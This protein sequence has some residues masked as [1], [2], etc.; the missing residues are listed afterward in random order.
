MSYRSTKNS[1]HYFI[2]FLLC[3]LLTSYITTAQTHYIL[4]R[5]LNGADQSP[6]PFVHL[7]FN[8]GN[9]G[10]TTNIDGN[11]SIPDTVSQVQFSY[12]GFRPM[13]LE[14]KKQSVTS[15]V[16]YLVPDDNLLNTIEVYPRK[17][18]A[19]RIMQMVLNHSDSN[20]PDQLNSYQYT[21]YHK[22]WLS[23]DVPSE[24]KFNGKKMI[25]AR[26]IEKLQEKF[27]A[28]HMLL[29]ETLSKKKFLKPNHE[30]EEIISSKV[31]GLKKE[32]FFLLSNQLQS[33]SIYKQ[34]F[35]LLG[36]NYLSPIN[37]SALRNYA[38]VLEDTL[39]IENQDT[40]FRIR[41]HPAK[42][43]NFDG[44]KGFLHINT[45]GYAVESVIIEPASDYKKE[46]FASVWQH[47]IRI[48]DSHWFPAE[49]NAAVNF[50]M[51]TTLPVDSLSK[52][53]QPLKVSITANSRSYL[54][55]TDINPTLDPKSFPK[56]GVTRLPEKKDS[57]MDSSFRH[58]PL[59]PKDS[60]TYQ[61]L[62]SLGKKARIYRKVRFL[63]ALSLGTIPVG[64]VSINF[65]YLF[66]YN[67]NEGY[68]L[69]LGL[70]TNRKFSK[71]FTL[72]NYFTYGMRDR[73]F[74]HGEWLRIYP[75]GY[76]DFKIQL[77]YRDVKRDFGEEELLTDFNI[78]E[79]E[80]FRSLLI[81][82]MYRT[83]N[84]SAS[85][86]IRPIEPLNV[87]FYVDRSKNQRNS[88]G[89]FTEYKWDPFYLTKIGLEFRYSPGIAFMNNS[90]DLI[91]S[92]PPKSDFF[93][94]VIQGLKLFNSEY[95]FTKLDSK[96]KFQL[97]L[98]ALGT[99]TVMIRG[100]KIF[101]TAPI[102]DWFHG[103]GSNS[104]RFT[105]L[106]HYAF[107]TMGLNEFS[108][109]QYASLH[110]RH[111]FGT[112]F[113]PSWYFIRPELVLVQNIGV[114][115][116]KQEYSAL[117]GATDF[118][119]GFFESGIELNKILNSNITG[120]GFGTY[121]RYGPYKLSNKA[122]NFAYKLTINFKF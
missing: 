1:R 55:Q 107:A 88:Y 14:I 117:S 65:M 98:S 99:T 72:G 50:N 16:I 29:I 52:K 26:E 35:T 84:L 53:K 63:H 92:S 43:R 13:N 93:F 31:A 81:M 111:N 3:L 118:R 82:N 36:R 47:Y 49:L 6:L 34:N 112:G 2:L 91:Q 67:I 5:V 46:V 110:I 86:E 103:Y 23:A 17:D 9:S 56:Y 94:S 100:G 60:A 69:G 27:E 20:D 96:A 73:Q 90:E 51:T 32:T 57:A 58:I 89:N 119:K 80:Y 61:Y 102:T 105:L 74:R 85:V 21:S 18:P 68:K 97:P 28:S 45:H 120:I 37:K 78:F 104:G 76:A 4:G 64:P 115:S 54:Y 114:G 11:F 79:P 48:G 40:T 19:Y 113:I 108:A 122:Q 25:S 10:T 71:Y 15:L 70:E 95:Q 59:T 30:N 38:F 77:G 75:K 109:D 106:P 66:G 44:L 39:Q 116:L 62:D 87:K 121:Y 33:F 83:Q 41:F 22:F 42:D 8:H 24:E 7:R 101:N 12:I